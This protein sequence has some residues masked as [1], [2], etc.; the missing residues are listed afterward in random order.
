MAK[1]S[2]TSTTRREKKKVSNP[3]VHA[4]TRTSN[5]KTSKHYKKSYRGQG[6]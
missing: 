5:S 6:K 4:K 3:G 1:A 2:S